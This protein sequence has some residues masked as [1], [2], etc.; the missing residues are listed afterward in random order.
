MPKGHKKYPSFI[1]HVP[2]EWF[3]LNSNSALLTIVYWNYATHIVRVC[4][5]SK[6]PINPNFPSPRKVIFK[7]D[8]VRELWPVCTKSYAIILSRTTTRLRNCYLT[9]LP[10]F[11][12]TFLPISHM[13]VSITNQ[14]DQSTLQFLHF[15]PLIR[16]IFPRQF[17]SYSFSCN[18]KF[19]PRGQEQ[20]SKK[21]PPTDNDRRPKRG[22]EDPK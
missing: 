11:L 6:S 15:L 10:D 14:S 17:S 13:K 7:L 22:P 2:P 21:E 9:S 16:P 19:L 1:W 12:R 3:G 20:D 18:S 5:C 8:L 4:V